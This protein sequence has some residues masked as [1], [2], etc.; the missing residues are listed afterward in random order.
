L[1]EVRRLV[2]DEYTGEGGE[3]AVHYPEFSDE[4]LAQRPDRTAGGTVSVRT[5]MHYYHLG[6]GISGLSRMMLIRLQRGGWTCPLCGES[7]PD[8]SDP[9]GKR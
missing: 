5:F 1:P 6:L 8:G 3:V 7:F 9:R 4:D 2:E